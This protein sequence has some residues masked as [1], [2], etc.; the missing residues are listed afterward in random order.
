MVW[1][2]VDKQ[3]EDD[4]NQWMDEVHIPN[5]VQAEGFVGGRKF[6]VLRD[7]AGLSF[8]YVTVYEIKTLDAV[9]SYQSGDYA[10]AMRQ[11]VSDRYG[12]QVMSARTVLQETS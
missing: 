3:I 7:A 4:W 12:Y 1:A 5:V 8:N 10:D 9:E 6:K 2:Q 11:E